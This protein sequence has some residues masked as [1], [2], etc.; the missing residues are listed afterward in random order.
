M[1]KNLSLTIYYINFSEIPL[2]LYRMLMLLS[3]S[4]LFMLI[5]SYLSNFLVVM[6]TSSQ[7]EQKALFSH[8]YFLS[9]ERLLC[10]SQGSQSYCK[11]F[12][13]VKFWWASIFLFFEGFQSPNAFNLSL[14]PLKNLIFSNFYMPY[15][16]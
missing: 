16:N 13:Q 1:P 15:K 9:I 8:L 11:L 3:P 14:F 4:P 10:K 2:L 12:L 6:L 7:L 5:K